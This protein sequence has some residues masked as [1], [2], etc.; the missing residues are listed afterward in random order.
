MEELGNISLSLK[1]SSGSIICQNKI[2]V[3]NLSNELMM[4]VVPVV[5]VV[6]AAAWAS[7]DVCGLA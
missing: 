2:T 7:A 5:L 3:I 1:F 4:V 6:A